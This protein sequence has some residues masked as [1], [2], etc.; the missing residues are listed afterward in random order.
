MIRTTTIS[1][2]S[3]L[4]QKRARPRSVSPT[5]SA[6][7]TANASITRDLDTRERQPKRL[8]RS[9]DIPAYDA[10]V[11]A[12]RLAMANPLNRKGLRKAAKKA[13]RADR[14]KTFGTM[15]DGGMEVDDV[16]MEGTFMD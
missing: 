13:R 3:V 1:T 4:S 14:P 16:G 7:S 2:T 15:G 8:R 10:P 9:H 6:F 5:P 12:D 11:H